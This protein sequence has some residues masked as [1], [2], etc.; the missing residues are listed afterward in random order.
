[1]HTYTQHL[2]TELHIPIYTSTRIKLYIPI[3]F[4]TNTPIFIFKCTHIYV[5]T[6]IPACTPINSC[7]HANIHDTHYTCPDT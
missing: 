3:F 1:M 5:N 2:H 7:V 6:A 4:N